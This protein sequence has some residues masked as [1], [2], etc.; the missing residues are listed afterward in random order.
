VAS[1]ASLPRDW[2]IPKQDFEGAMRFV[3]AESREGDLITT[4]DITTATYR[5]YYGQDW[6]AV[7]NAPE[8]QAV[9]DSVTGKVW[10]IYTFPRYLA[11][12]DSALEATVDRECRTERVFPATLGGGDVVVCSFPGGGAR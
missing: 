12:F 9:R 1:A 10:M 2:T 4:A 7:H 11:L 5:L 3:A 8:L 6:R